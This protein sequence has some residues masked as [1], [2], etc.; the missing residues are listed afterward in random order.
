MKRSEGY[1]ERFVS[2]AII[3]GHALIPTPG[4]PAPKNLLSHHICNFV[5]I[6]SK[7]CHCLSQT[8]NVPPFYP[9]D[10]AARTKATLQ[11]TYKSCSPW[12]RRFMSKIQIHRT[13][14][15]TFFAR[16]M[17]TDGKDM[18]WRHWSQSFYV[19]ATR[20]WS[21]FRSQWSHSTTRK[22]DYELSQMRCMS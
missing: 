22:G 2:P 17:S 8:H 21:W 4:L 16:L 14:K 6:E 3:S 13:I 20:Q 19:G 11:Q 18:S 1:D 9:P 15:M 10:S 5:N 12:R 7:H